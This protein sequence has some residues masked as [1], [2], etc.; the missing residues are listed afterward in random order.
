MTLPDFSFENKLNS[1]NFFSN[2]NR[3]RK[4]LWNF[5]FNTCLALSMKETD[6]D[7]KFCSILSSSFL[8]K[9]SFSEFKLFKQLTNEVFKSSLCFFLISLNIFVHSFI[10]SKT[11]S[12]LILF[13]F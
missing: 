9:D 13:L 6:I 3:F 11:R 1:I 10:R 4:C 8:D 2:T 7:N 12:S 5:K